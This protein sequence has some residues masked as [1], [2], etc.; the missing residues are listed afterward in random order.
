MRV[1]LALVAE[2]YRAIVEETQNCYL[3]MREVAALSVSGH[4]P[5]ETRSKFRRVLD[6]LRQKR[7]LP[8]RMAVRL[9]RSRP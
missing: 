1:R 2:R 3:T 7:K 5:E 9:V 4:T 8:R 6:A